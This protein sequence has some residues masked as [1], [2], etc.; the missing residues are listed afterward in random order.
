MEEQGGK[1]FNPA[2]CLNR[3]VADVIC[4]ITFGEG[5]DTT[6]PHLK[7]L[8]QLNVDLVVNT[9][10]LQLVQML[11]FFPV[12]QYLPLKA[13]DRFLQPIYEIFDIIRIFLR[14]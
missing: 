5:Y 11:E 8:L 2:D 6:N 14:E 9:D 3:A 4:G 13:Y 10:D 1:P 12:A 7:T